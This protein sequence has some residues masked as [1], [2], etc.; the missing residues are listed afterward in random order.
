MIRPLTADDAEELAELYR[1]NRSYLAPFEP[2]RTDG[3][4]TVAEQRRRLAQRTDDRYRFAIV[5]DGAIAGTINVNDILRGALQ[6][7]NIG[8]WVA[9]AHA[10]RGLATGALAELIPIA[11]GRLGLHRLEAGTLPDNFASQRVL[12]KN[13]FTKFGYA[14]QLLLI[15][16]VWR[17]H[18]LFELLADEV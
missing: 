3:F 10:G 15:Q 6:M 12:E 1:V 7:G 8:Y 9:E 4:F 18:V 14:R 17:D 2:T 13:G 5:A 16:D 11:F